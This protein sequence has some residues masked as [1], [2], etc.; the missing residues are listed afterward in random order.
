VAPR[1]SHTKH[2]DVVAMTCADIFASNKIAWTCVVLFYFLAWKLKVKSW[3]INNI[4]LYN[5][6][7]N[8]D[9]ISTI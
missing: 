9:N 4:N 6:I 8:F 5:I 2:V 1:W 7:I 3:I